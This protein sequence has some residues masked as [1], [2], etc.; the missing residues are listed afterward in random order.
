MTWAQTAT[1][2]TQR[3][4][5][6]WKMPTLASSA[7]QARPVMAAYRGDTS[8]EDHHHMT[9]WRRATRRHHTVLVSQRM[10]L[11]T[12]QP[13]FAISADADKL[14]PVGMS[15]EEARRQVDEAYEQMDV[16]V[17]A[18]VDSLERVRRTERILCCP[19][20]FA[21]PAV[22][23]LAVSAPS[24]SWAVDDVI[25]AP[26]P[27]IAASIKDIFLAGYSNP[28]KRDN[29]LKRMYVRTKKA[30]PQKPPSG[31]A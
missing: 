29:K 26:F 15:L 27:R 23:M 20:A 1:M 9:F 31:Y 7:R 11:E 13:E 14:H 10:H 3:A 25:L 8:V 18:L 2:T 19:S 22:V 21:Q 24:T 5:A 6:S 30:L 17:K 12:S 4:K 28:D 16:H